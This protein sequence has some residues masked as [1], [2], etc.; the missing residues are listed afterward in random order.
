M[1]RQATA[2]AGNG[3]NTARGERTPGAGKGGA[4]ENGKQ[5]QEEEQD[6]GEGDEDEEEEEEAGRGFA[7]GDAVEANYEGEGEWF[8]CEVTAAHG[9]GR[10]VPDK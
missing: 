9:D 3:D 5:Q 4:S 6:G 2:L 1:E 7:V 10:C 8:E